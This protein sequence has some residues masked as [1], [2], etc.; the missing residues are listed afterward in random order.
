MSNEDI[1]KDRIKSYLNAN[2]HDGEDRSGTKDTIIFQPDDLE[3]LVSDV[4]Y[5]VLEGLS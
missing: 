3:E 2:I 4:V 5:Y 1:I